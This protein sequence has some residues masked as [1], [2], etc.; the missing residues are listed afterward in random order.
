MFVLRKI[1]VDGFIICA[2]IFSIY[3]THYLWVPFHRGFFCGDESLMFPYRSDTVSTT[4]LRL[5][6]LGLPILTF[7]ICEWVV[8]RK[9][10]TN[11]L[12][13]NIPV[14]TWLRGFYCAATSFALGT[15]FVEL[16]TNIAK[17]VIGRPR[18]HFLDLCQPSVDCS[19]P[20]WRGRYIQPD[21]YTCTGTNTEKF[22]DMYMSFLSGH[23][24]LS[25]YSNQFKEFN[26]PSGN[27]NDI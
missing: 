12:C 23:S 11:R 20:A 25:A 3:A 24:A 5:V 4:T 27:S 19:M 8:L 7:L 17:T 10:G 26:H 15:C 22:S 9:E 14:P 16:T 13:L 1:V 18:P 2:L 6:G 21:E